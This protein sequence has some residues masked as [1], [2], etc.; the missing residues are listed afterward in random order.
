[1]E[2]TRLKLKK[3]PYPRPLKKKTKEI[4]IFW[5]IELSSLKPKKTKTFL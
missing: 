1:M 4:L 2:L 5:G 3:L